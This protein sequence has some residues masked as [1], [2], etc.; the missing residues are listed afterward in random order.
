LWK[1]VVIKNFRW[2]HP[3]R[4]QF[5]ITSEFF[6]LG[7]WPSFARTSPPVFIKISK[8]SLLIWIVKKKSGLKIY[9]RP[10]WDSS[11]LYEEGWKT[12]S[13][14]CSNPY[15][16]NLSH[17]VKKNALEGETVCLCYGCNKRQGTDSWAVF[18]NKQG[19]TVTRTATSGPKKKL[20]FKEEKRRASLNHLILMLK[21]I[22]G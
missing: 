1:R 9:K 4:R 16:L 13:S 8:K 7:G 17:E 6:E 3:P 5:L 18:R 20:F 2:E 14:R 15:L 22:S 10:S 12:K 11:E 21:W 19:K